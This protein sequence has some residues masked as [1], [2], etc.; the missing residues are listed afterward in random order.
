MHFAAGPLASLQGVGMLR[1]HC[2]PQTGC[3]ELVAWV[4]EMMEEALQSTDC[5]LRCMTGNP[6]GKFAQSAHCTCCAAAEAA[7]NSGG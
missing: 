6:I 2:H 5:H 4:G 3:S 1:Q 7:S